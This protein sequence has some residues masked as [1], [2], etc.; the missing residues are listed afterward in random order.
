MAAADLTG[1]P[2]LDI[3]VTCVNSARLAL[4]TPEGGGYRLS[5]RPMPGSPYGLAAADFFGTGKCNP[6][7]FFLSKPAVFVKL[8]LHCRVAITRRFRI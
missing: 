1:G 4:L 2:L 3:A 7:G 5:F 8:S 6:P